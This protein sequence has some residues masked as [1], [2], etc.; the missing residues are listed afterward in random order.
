[1]NLKVRWWTQSKRATVVA[2]HA[3]VI[4]AVKRALDEAS[5]EI[6]Y[7]KQVLYLHGETVEALRANPS[8]DPD[9]A[10]RTRT[11]IERNDPLRPG[12]GASDRG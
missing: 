6:P 8:E 9:A 7:P 12:S 3:R 10:A 11:E 5:V 1:V 4:E 2:V